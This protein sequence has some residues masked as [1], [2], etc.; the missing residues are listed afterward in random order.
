MKKE[1]QEIKCA[2]GENCFYYS[3][4]S[5]CSDCSQN[6]NCDKPI[7]DYSKELQKNGY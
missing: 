1:Q 7:K 2:V 5:I 3:I 6:K 4:L